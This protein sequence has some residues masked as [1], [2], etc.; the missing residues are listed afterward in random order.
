MKKL[1]YAS[2]AYMVIGQIAGVYYRELVRFTE[3]T[4]KSQLATVHTHAFSLGM[5]ML[6]VILA[7]D[8]TFELSKSPGFNK[9]FVT[10][11]AGLIG[12][13]V[14]MTLRGTLQVYSSD[15]GGLNYVSGLMHA[16]F[17]TGVVW[18]FLLLKKRLSL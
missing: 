9:W 1:F 8:K 18:F 17:A 7:L 11:N 2:F 13:L 14:T 15:I 6:L 16:I 3:F 12:V 10:Y 5:M 4:G